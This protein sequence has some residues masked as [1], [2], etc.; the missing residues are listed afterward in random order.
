MVKNPSWQEANQLVI[1]KRGRGVEPGDTE[2]QL[3]LMVRTGLPDSKS[4]A[5]TT[6]PRCLKGIYN[7]MFP[8]STL[9]CDSNIKNR[10]SLKRE[11]FIISRLLLLA[12]KY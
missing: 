6:R 4:G 5:L 3:Q 11:K 9:D 12:M 7:E 8:Y 2:K 1:Y 10:P